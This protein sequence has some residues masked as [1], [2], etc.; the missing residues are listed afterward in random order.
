MPI[1]FIAVMPIVL[2]A[3]DSRQ[4]VIVSIIPVHM[5]GQL[6]AGPH[7]HDWRG[8]LGGGGGDLEPV[9]CVGALGVECIQ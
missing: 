9:L 6:K 8:G 3:C 1:G 4:A 5:Q 2:I 7:W